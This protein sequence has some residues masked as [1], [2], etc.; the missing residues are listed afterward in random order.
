M[1]AAEAGAAAIDPLLTLR[2]AV[3]SNIE[4]IPTKSPDASASD[5]ELNLAKATHVLFNFTNETP[6]S[7]ELSTP[8]RFISSGNAVDFRSIYLAW[9][10]KDATVTDYLAA[11]RSVNAD[12]ANADEG[13]VGGEV[14]NLIFAEKLDLITWL[15]S[16]GDSEYIKPLAEDENLKAAN[17]EA[18]IA[19]GDLDVT[20]KDV[21]GVA[22]AGALRAGQKTVDPRLQEIYNSERKM[23]DRNSCLRG[24]KPTDFS[25]VRKS[26]EL[27]LG[28]ASRPRPGGPTAVQPPQNNPLISNL[29]RPGSAPS[30]R[31]PEPIILLSPS[32]SSLL[33]MTNIKSFL[34]DGLY[35][36]PDTSTATPNILHVSR[37]LPSISSHPLRFILVD[38]P[39]QFKPDYWS[40][41]VAIFTTGQAWQFK[42]YKWQQPAELF[43]HALGVYVGWR[44]EEVPGTVKG[45]GRQ[46][47]SVQVDKWNPSQGTKGRWRD[48]EVVE[49]VW[50]KIE[51][52]M[53]ARGW[54]KEGR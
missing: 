39:D 16:A 7:F 32:A 49:G 42:S 6:L 29:K 26:A 36:P 47:A 46:V 27:F 31:R 35:Q 9:Q 50:G 38:T 4:P 8:T 33:R 54:G 15:E 2:R 17:R 41:V 45:W 11:T 30:G 19:R 3:S 1:A 10:N 24:I 40:R 18:A 14:K 34:L 23:G 37:T 22:S 48:R 52:S 28:R 13:G 20:M 25:H 44:G 43:S 5:T 12:L 51:E 21:N 53:R